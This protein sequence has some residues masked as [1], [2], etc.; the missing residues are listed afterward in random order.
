MA[1]VGGPPRMRLFPAL[2]AVLGLLVFLKISGLA[3]DGRYSLNAVST[4][5]AQNVPQAPQGESQG[6]AQDAGSQADGAKAA[7]DGAEAPTV[8]VETTTNSS[9]PQPR[10]EGTLEAGQGVRLNPPTKAV[11]TAELALLESLRKRRS[12]LEA[13]ASAL[14]VRENLLKAAEQRIDEK[15]KALKVFDAKI[16][17]RFKA[18]EKAKNDQFANLVSMYENMKPKDAARIFNRLESVVLLNVA[19]RMSPR[20]LAPVLSRMESAAAERLTM[21][22]ARA[23]TSAG[24]STGELESLAT[25]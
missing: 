14:E 3:L 13:R 4:A 5:I 22:I 25:N 2:V 6:A 16:E 15:L 10:L 18:Q 12:E 19:S 8:Q 23:A 11:S 7:G 17:A 24:P 20:K 9:L 21:E 1:I